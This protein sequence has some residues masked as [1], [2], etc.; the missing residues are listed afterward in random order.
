MC[1]P[2]IV[3][4][5]CEAFNFKL[6]LADM[7]ISE[8]I[9]PMT[10]NIYVLLYNRL[11]MFE[12][13][14]VAEV[15]GLSRP[16]FDHH[17]YQFHTFSIDNQAVDTQYHGQMSPT[18]KLEQL[19][20]PATI[21]IPGWENIE[22][23]PSPELIELLN[24]AYAAGSRI[25]TICSGV[26]ALAHSGLLDGKSATTHW[27]YLSDFS[28]KFDRVQVKD[29][30]LFVEDERLFTSAGSAA[31]LDLCL[32]LV[33]QDYGSKVVN[34]VARR[35]VL[36]P[37]REGSQA[38]FVEAPVIDCPMGSVSSITEKIQANLA[39]DWSLKQLANT[40][41]MSERTLL[42]KFKQA[43]GTSPAKWLIQARVQ[44]AG[45]LLERTQAPIEVVAN[46]CGFGTAAKFRQHFKAHLAI[47]P[48][49]YRRQ[50]QP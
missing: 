1:P 6:T 41:A 32:N 49:A 27:R 35:L 39:Q 2:L 45:E 36:P 9:P 4:L 22:S 47:S 12:F 40:F 26:Y 16:E 34:S 43:T 5:H 19:Q 11:C 7:T 29:D 17:W 23:I 42:R 20:F 13:G 28:N 15:F 30:T 8:R 38:Q 25:V 33:R 21:I 44:R 14:C 37:L 18:V 48:Q 31:G 10:N 24:T 3:K 50:F 46:D